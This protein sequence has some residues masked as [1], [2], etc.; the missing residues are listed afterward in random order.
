MK[1]PADLKYTQHDEWVRLDGD[2]L[3]IGITDYAQDALGDLVHVEL[4]SI[5]ARFDAGAELAEVES[6]KA[7][8]QIYTPVSG[9]VVDVNSD[10]DESP[11]AVNEDPY[12][13]WMVKLRVTDRAGL[14]ALMDAAA[15]EKK[16]T[17]N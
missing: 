17:P 1:F 6:V 5:G 2:T 8:A 9:E 10:L 14:E 3:V 7:V 11:E 12:G 15:Y 4:P 13:A 16:V